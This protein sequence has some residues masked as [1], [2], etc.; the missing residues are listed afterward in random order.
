MKK[1]ERAATVIAITLLAGTA[2][3]DD[4]QRLPANIIGVWDDLFE[5]KPSCT[6]LVL[7][8]EPTQV[9]QHLDGGS[10]YCQIT[11]ITSKRGII[12][13]DY[14]CKWDASVPEGMREGPDEED[15]GFS[16]KIKSNDQ[17][18]YNN[19]SMGRCSSGGKN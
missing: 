10:G 16:L 13:G 2:V 12:Y 6:R 18:V 4:K 1:F 8:I 7:T 17:I 3:A 11:R 19:S 14:K 9:I 15:N 5:G